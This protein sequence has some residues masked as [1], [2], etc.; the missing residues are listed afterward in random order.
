MNVVWVC[1]CFAVVLLTSIASSVRYEPNWESLDKRPLPPWYDEA[2]IGIFL[3]WG[4]FSVPS[5]ESAWFVKLWKDGRP[6]IVKFMKDNYRPGF[7]YA[8]FASQ[9]T[10]EFYDPVEWARLFSNSGASS[11]QSFTIPWSG[12]NYLKRLVPGE[13]YNGA[14]PG[15]HSTILQGF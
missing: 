1:P 5:F 10:A 2:K 11:Q 15:A 13:I 8:D 12:R 9:F 6:S 3:H 14:D 4:V 7:T